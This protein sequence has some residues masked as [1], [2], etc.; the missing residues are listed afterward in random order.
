MA[1]PF[2]HPP[3]GLSHPYALPPSCSRSP[4]S[5]YPPLYPGFKYEDLQVALNYHAQVGPP[6]LGGRMRPSHTHLPCTW[7]LAE[8]PGV[9]PNQGVV[10]S[11]FA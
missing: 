7:H 6:P 10:N 9:S 4:A 5:A 2:A 11:C 8:M 3:P 1:G